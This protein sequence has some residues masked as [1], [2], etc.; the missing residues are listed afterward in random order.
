[1]THKNCTN[2]I[3]NDLYNFLDQKVEKINDFN[4]LRKWHEIY[5]N[6]NVISKYFTNT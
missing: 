5:P 6:N 1:M 4:K 2:N 3:K